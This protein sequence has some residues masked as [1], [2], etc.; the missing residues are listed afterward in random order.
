MVWGASS[1]GPG[2]GGLPGQLR[3]DPLEGVG[4]GVVHREGGKGEQA[5]S[6]LP[7]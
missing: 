5:S 4:G 1:S 3:W 2:S 6:N 7:V